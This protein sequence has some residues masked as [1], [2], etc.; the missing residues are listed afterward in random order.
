MGPIG[1]PEASV[2]NYHS[3][4]RNMAEERRSDLQRGESLKSRKLS[5][6]MTLSLFLS[7]NL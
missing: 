7:I 3:T 4:M 6:F 2:K 5:S 1:C